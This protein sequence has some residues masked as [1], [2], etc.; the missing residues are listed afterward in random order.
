MKYKSFEEIPVW[1][2]SID[3][4]RRV[5][6]L[7][8]DAAFRHQGDI[9]NQLQRAALSVPSNI[10][11]GF[12][13][14]TIPELL[15]FI[16]FAKGSAGEVRSI[17][18]VVERLPRFTALASQVAEVRHLTESISNQLGAWARSQ[19]DSP[20][21]GK[22]YLDQP[23]REARETQKRRDTFMAHAREVTEENIRRTRSCHAQEP[24]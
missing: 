3:L 22:R 8:E 13:R 21:Q 1:R 7:S 6:L 19:R 5:F 24:E 14:G 10:A 15:Q 12:E 11:E 23:A 2:D 16:Y 20:F 4:A 17:C 9:A 18:H